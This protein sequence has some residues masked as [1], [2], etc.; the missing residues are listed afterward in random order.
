MKRILVSLV[1]LSHSVHAVK[2]HNLERVE[3][4]GVA[5]DKEVPLKLEE[6]GSE[7]LYGF[8]HGDF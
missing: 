6:Q 1:V 5:N 7:K 4:S 2:T 3:A 8:S